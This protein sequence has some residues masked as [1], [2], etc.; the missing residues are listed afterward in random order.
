MSAMRPA[1]SSARAVSA[2][3]R[4]SERHGVCRAAIA[5]E[6]PMRR[7]RRWSLSDVMCELRRRIQPQ[8]LTEEAVN[9]RLR[10]RYNEQTERGRADTT[11][12]RGAVRRRCPAGKNRAH[13]HE[14]AQR[15]WGRRKG[16]SW[17][18][19]RGL[20]QLPIP[21]SMPMSMLRV[22]ARP[23]D[24]SVGGVYTFGC[25]HVAFSSIVVLKTIKSPIRYDQN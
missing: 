2:C 3:G 7:V 13:C 19:L 25:C 23:S 11:R 4:H 6:S 24:S 18:R 9:L 22:S 14:S 21:I 15:S 8:G 1:I 5:M 12:R 10:Q 16:L 20:R 17:A